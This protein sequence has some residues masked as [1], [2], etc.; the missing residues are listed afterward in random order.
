MPPDHSQLWHNQTAP[1]SGSTVTERHGSDL[2]APGFVVTR[3][4]AFEFNSV[5]SE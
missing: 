4:V 5:F 2:W 3:R 1:P